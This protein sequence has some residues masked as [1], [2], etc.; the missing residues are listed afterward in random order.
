VKNVL[1]GA[2]VEIEIAK[3][4]YSPDGKKDHRLTVCGVAVRDSKYSL[5]I[6][7]D[8]NAAFEDHPEIKRLRG[9][10][11]VAESLWNFAGHGEFCDFHDK[12]PCSCGY[13]EVDK[14]YLMNRSAK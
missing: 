5:R 10:E 7:M 12:K 13:E 9:I 1:K 14:S 11:K 2:R 4:G 8:I 6:A 3:T